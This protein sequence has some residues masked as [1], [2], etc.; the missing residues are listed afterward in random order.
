MELPFAN[1]GRDVGARR[2]TGAE[3]S[4]RKRSCVALG[5]RG[6]YPAA[7]DECDLF[8]QGKCAQSPVSAAEIQEEYDLVIVDVTTRAGCV[9]CHQQRK[10]VRSANDPGGVP[11][12]VILNL[13]AGLR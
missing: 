4:G 6:N 3:R 11:R 5:L 2:R 13:I 10:A 8:R 7:V 9:D 12:S 1:H